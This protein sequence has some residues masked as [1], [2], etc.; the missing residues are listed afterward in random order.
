MAIRSRA[1]KKRHRF[2]IDNH[3]VPKTQIES[4]KRLPAG[5]DVKWVGNGAKKGYVSGV[6]RNTETRAIDRSAGV[7]V[8][9]R[10]YPPPPVVLSPSLILAVLG[11]VQSL[12]YLQYQSLTQKTRSLFVQKCV[13]PSPPSPLFSPS[14]APSSWPQLPNWMLAYLSLCHLV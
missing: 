10:T 9:S 6:T 2:K 5:I 14:P 12:V 13:S 3:R 4:V 8:Q 1:S 7:F 11:I